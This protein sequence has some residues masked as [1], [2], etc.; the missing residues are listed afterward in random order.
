M[1][2]IVQSVENCSF[3]KTVWVQIDNDAIPVTNR[4]LK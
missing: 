3:T 4:L 1:Y 2:G